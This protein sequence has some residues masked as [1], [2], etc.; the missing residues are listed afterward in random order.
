M[1]TR[2]TNKPVETGRKR[3]MAEA[4]PS[5]KRRVRAEE[6]KALVLGGKKKAA[7]K[8][9][10]AEPLA[11]DSKRLSVEKII[12]TLKILGDTLNIK[13]SDRFAME[14]V[15]LVTQVPPGKREEIFQL[16][17]DR[18]REG[19]AEESRSGASE[20]SRPIPGCSVRRPT[21]DISSYDQSVSGRPEGRRSSSLVHLSG[22]GEAALDKAEDE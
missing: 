4:A 9:R 22:E 15:D 17:L 16:M 20:A 10:F 19:I 3:L 2:R 18:V 1:T 8:R 5:P 6:G 21:P 7:G 14:F 12:S 11:E 13:V